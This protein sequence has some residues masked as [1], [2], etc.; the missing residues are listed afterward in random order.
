[1]KQIRTIG[2]YEIIIYNPEQHRVMEHV[3]NLCYTESRDYAKA[4][5]FEHNERYLSEEQIA[6][7]VTYSYTVSKLLDNSIYNVHMP[8]RKLYE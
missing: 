8:K 2:D 4:L 3:S 7:G 6:Q 1:M 5:V